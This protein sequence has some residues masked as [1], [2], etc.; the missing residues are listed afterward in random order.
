MLRIDSSLSHQ[1][2][3]QT[4]E[5]TMHTTTKDKRE[6]KIES[7]FC[8]PLSRIIW[9]LWETLESA[10]KRDEEK[11]THSLIIFYWPW[12]HLIYGRANNSRFGKCKLCDSINTNS[13]KIFFFLHYSINFH[14]SITKMVRYRCL[15]RSK[16]VWYLSSIVWARSCPW[17]NVNNSPTYWQI[18]VP[19]DRS[20]KARKAQPFIAIVK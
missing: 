2:T 3:N 13:M 17:S 16:L 15:T 20:C 10:R 12:A 14:R 18:N 5:Q 8:L 7:P 1:T 19:N 6:R 4:I 11:K 9:V